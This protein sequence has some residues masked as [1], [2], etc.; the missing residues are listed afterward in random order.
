M[1]N[2]NGP[3]LIGWVGDTSGCEEYNV[4][5]LQSKIEIIFQTSQSGTGYTV[6]KA[7]AADSPFASIRKLQ[8]GSLVV[9]K[10]DGETN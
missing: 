3:W 1:G 6:Q 4:S 9:M 10:L 8:C 5:D 7:N 2:L